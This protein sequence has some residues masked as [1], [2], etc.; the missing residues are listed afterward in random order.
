M[1]NPA[2]LTWFTPSLTFLIPTISDAISH[3][4]IHPSSDLEGTQFSGPQT[5]NSQAS[6]SQGSCGLGLSKNFP[7]K[8]TSL[9]QPPPALHGLSWFSEMFWRYPFLE[10]RFT[11]THM[12]SW[13]AHFEQGTKHYKN[14][15]VLPWSKNNV[16]MSEKKEWTRLDGS[17]LKRLHKRFTNSLSGGFSPLPFP[18]CS[19]RMLGMLGVDLFPSCGELVTKGSRNVT[20]FCGG[21]SDSEEVMAVMAQHP[22]QCPVTTLGSDGPDL[23]R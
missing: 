21:L 13:S 11:K 10:P 20:R 17:N 14:S 22:W 18:T 19:A 12:K 8:S 23:G 7:R 1:N 9:P 4:E 2:S 15:C 6:G 5:A 3:R 16:S